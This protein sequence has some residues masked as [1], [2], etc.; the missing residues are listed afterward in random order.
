MVMLENHYRTRDLGWSLCPE[1]SGHHQ[2]TPDICL[3]RAIF[4]Q[5]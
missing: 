5:S 4:A 3:D 2:E 1:Y